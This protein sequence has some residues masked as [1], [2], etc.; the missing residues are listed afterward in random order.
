MDGVDQV[1]EGLG[2]DETQDEA[3]ADYY[4]IGRGTNPANKKG[5]KD[6]KR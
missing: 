1:D 5:S 2:H 3:H 4:G 6:T